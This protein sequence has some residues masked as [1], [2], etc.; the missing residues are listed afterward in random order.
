[1]SSDVGP[2]E[3]GVVELILTAAR[4]PEILSGFL[5]EL[6]EEPDH[7]SILIV[8]NESTPDQIM[9]IV[10]EKLGSKPG[11]F[12]LIN[13]G[14]GTRSTGLQ[15]ES[16]VNPTTILTIVEDQDISRL[17]TTINLY[18]NQ[19][20]D[21][22]KEIRIYFNSLSNLLETVSLQQLFRFLHL[23]IFRIREIGAKG[24][25][26]LNPKNFDRQTIKTVEPL[27]DVVAGNADI[28]AVGDQSGQVGID[29]LNGDSAESR[30]RRSV[31]SF[32]LEKQTPVD[33]RKLTEWVLDRNI[34]AV[35]TPWNGD[36][37]QFDEI[38][39]SLYHIQIPKLVNAGLVVTDQSNE[40]VEETRA[41]NRVAS[42]I[43]DNEDEP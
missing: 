40:L 28:V 19:W 30:L 11:K 14:D 32:L 4:E 34:D 12:G 26:Y 16:S 9:S 1:M 17:G 6:E 33:L 42:L 5:S 27:F 13:V 10:G 25:F 15:T 29:E 39:Y 37:D 3:S 35:G 36:R 2:A 21:N 20:E 23:L 22:D 38:Y 8:S 7:Y 43:R 18:L 24:Q 31:L 41:A